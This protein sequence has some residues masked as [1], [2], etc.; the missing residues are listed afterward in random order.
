MMYVLL[1]SMAWVVLARQLLPRSST[2]NSLS[3][4][5]SN[6]VASL[7]MFEKHHNKVFLI[8]K[9]NLSLRFENRNAAMTLLMSM[10]ESTRSKTSFAERKL[11]LFLTMLM[12]N[13]NLIRLQESM[14]DLV[15][16]VGS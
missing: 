5:V 3:L 10:K 16:E 15:Q 4:C 14:I 7:Q 2:T 9:S 13:L 11:S 6:V 8:C 1:E 12:K